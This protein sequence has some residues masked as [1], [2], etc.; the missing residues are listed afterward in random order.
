MTNTLHRWSDHY[1]FERRSGV[2]PVDNDYIVFAMATRNLNDDDL[3][4]KYQIGRAHV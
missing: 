4:E 1:S 3:V 2:P